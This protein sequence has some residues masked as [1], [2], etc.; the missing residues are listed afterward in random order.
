MLDPSELPPPAPRRSAPPS[1]PRVQR[2]LGFAAGLVAGMG[3][4][5]VIHLTTAN[6]ILGL[7]F[8][9]LPGLAIGVGLEVTAR[10]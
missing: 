1:T 8:G 2:P 7:V 5:A 3:L 6:L 9:L 4:W 10:R